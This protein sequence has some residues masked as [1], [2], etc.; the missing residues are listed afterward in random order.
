[1]LVQYTR[2]SS[3]VRSQSIAIIFQPFFNLSLPRALT[4]VGCAAPFTTTLT[5][6]S[7]LSLHLYSSIMSTSAPPILVLGGTGMIGS[8]LVKQLHTQGVPVVATVRETAKAK[9]KLPSRV[10]LLQVDL[11]DPQALQ[12]AA[13]TSG[14]KKIFAL[15][16]VTT[17]ES[18]EALKAGG[19]RHIVFVSTAFVGLPTETVP[20]QTWHIAAENAIRAAGLTYTFLRCEAFLSNS[21]PTTTHTV[22]SP[23]DHD[24]CPQSVILTRL[25]LLCVNH[26]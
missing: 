10:Q 11:K 24:V 3:P 21:Q 8:A 2:V 17:K 1:M 9:A 26:L 6:L 16:E 14:A 19:V 4:T 12:Q 25:P 18:L 15:Y 20:L 13:Q 5:P 23:A 7:Y 22:H